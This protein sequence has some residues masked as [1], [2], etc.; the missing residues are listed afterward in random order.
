MVDKVG[1]D[2]FEGENDGAGLAAGGGAEGGGAVEEEEVIIAVGAESGVAEGVIALEVLL[3]DGEV[4]LLQGGGNFGLVG[5]RDG[6]VISCDGAVNCG[7]ASVDSIGELGASA[8]EG[9]AVAGE[10]KIPGEKLVWGEGVGFEQ[11]VALLEG[12]VVAREVGGVGGIELRKNAVKISATRSGGLSDEI[13]VGRF[14]KDDGVAVFL[15]ETVIFMLGKMESFVL[16]IVGNGG[17]FTSG[18]L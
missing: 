11:L 18:E 13:E 10:E 14:K 5:N 12:F 8:V 4:C 15:G 2:E 3:E 9:K 16:P 6:V 7:E 17:F 1:F